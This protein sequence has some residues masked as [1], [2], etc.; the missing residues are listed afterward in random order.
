MGNERS[1]RIVSGALLLAAALVLGFDPEIL[2]PA[3]DWLERSLLAALLAGG[4]GALALL[5]GHEAANGM[6]A[7]F[8]RPRHAWGLMILGLAG[9]IAYRHVFPLLA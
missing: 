8:A 1:Q 5:I 6:L 4:I 7:F 3:A 9:L 2:T